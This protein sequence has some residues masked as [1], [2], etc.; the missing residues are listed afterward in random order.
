[1]LPPLSRY[2]LPGPRRHNALF[3]APPGCFLWRPKSERLWQ[4]S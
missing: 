2:Y 1:M 3:T 4:P